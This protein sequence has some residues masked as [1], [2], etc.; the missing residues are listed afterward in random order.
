MDH[1]RN[2]LLKRPNY[3]NVVKDNNLINNVYD[4]N[5]ASRIKDALDKPKA[6]G[7]ELSKSL[8]ASGN[9]KFYI[10]LAYQYHQETLFECLALTKEAQREGKIKTTPAQYFGAL[11][12]KRERNGK[13]V[14]NKSSKQA[15]MDA[16][17]LR[18]VR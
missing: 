15:R 8:N 2:T 1:I 11:L 12:K 14:D 4:D 18:R 7:E 13:F 17:L 5:V 16:E 6:I 9:L 10:K 3:V